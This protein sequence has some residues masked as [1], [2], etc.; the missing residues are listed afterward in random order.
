M[1]RRAATVVRSRAGSLYPLGLSKIDLRAWMNATVLTGEQINTAWKL[2]A[3]LHQQGLDGRDK[4]TLLLPK[5]WEGIAL[6]TKQ[7]FEESLGKCEELGIKIVIGEKPKMA[8]YR[9]PKDALQDRVFLAIQVKGQPGPDAQKLAM[10][11][12]AGYPVAVVAFAR[13]ALLSRYMEF[14][15]Y[16]VF[17][18]GKLR[19]MNF[20]T[21]PGVELYKS[22]TNGLYEGSGETR[23]HREDT[24][25]AETVFLPV[26]GQ[27]ARRSDPALR[28]SSVRRSAA[29]IV[30]SVPLCLAADGITVPAARWSTASLPFSATCAIRPRERPCASASTEPRKACSV[31]A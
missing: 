25:V 21:Q 18:M 6:W 19:G 14:M 10:L 4:V 20:V 24:R 27:V 7:D 29:E 22:I 16:A 1:R 17:G 13:G 28:T 26:T 15:H 23:R 12:R 30:G 11:R 8:N 9:A 3:F 2:S 5:I 31:R